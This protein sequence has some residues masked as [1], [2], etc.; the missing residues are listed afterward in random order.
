MVSIAYDTKNTGTLQ[1]DV[2]GKSVKSIVAQK[3]VSSLHTNTDIAI[4]GDTL[5]V[6]IRLFITTLDLSCTLFVK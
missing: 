4:L 3:S 6:R 1:T 2:L 5:S